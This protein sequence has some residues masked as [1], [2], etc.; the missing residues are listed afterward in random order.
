MQADESS[1]RIYVD[2]I[3]M[4]LFVHSGKTHV[5]FGVWVYYS[6]ILV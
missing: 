6:A 1:G 5:C 3:N 4:T 2:I